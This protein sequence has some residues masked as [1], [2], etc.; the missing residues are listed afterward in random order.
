MRVLLVE[1]ERKIAEFVSVGLSE[2]GYAVDVAYDGHEALHWK[3]VVDFDIIILDV[4]LPSLNGFE[5][6][7]RIR[8][9]ELR[10]RAGG[11][12]TGVARV[13]GT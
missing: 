12:G 8:A 4:M 7:R 10:S 2:Q 5:V 11:R 3:D 9:A 13:R 6:C 1:D